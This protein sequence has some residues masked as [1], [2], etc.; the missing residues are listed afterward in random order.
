[1]QIV[2]APQP[3]LAEKAKPILKIDKAIL[4][5]I[6]GM[7]Q[8]LLSAYDPEGVGLA[9]PQ[10]GKSLQL[11]LTKPTLKSDFEIFINPKIM[12]LETK[13]K[14]RTPIESGQRAANDT[15][16]SAQ[17]SRQKKLEGCL[18]LQ[19]I[20]GFVQRKP[21]VKAEYLD[22]NGKLHRQ[23][24]TGFMATILQHEYDHLQGILFPRRVL[25]QQNKLF[26]SSKNAQ[27]K[28]VFEEIE[29]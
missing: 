16:L 2:Q 3:V 1:M 14:E 28:E 12:L 20:W 15:Q 17:S 26:K 10:V 9:A 25:E 5:L 22:E 29:L 8:T 4:K 21:K 13:D 19:N 27:G 7:K 6:K 18:S 11:F 24:F 23:I